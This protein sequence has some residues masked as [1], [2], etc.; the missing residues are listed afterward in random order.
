MGFG[1]AKLSTTDQLH[2]ALSN[3]IMKKSMFSLLV[4]YLKSRKAPLIYS[5]IINDEEN[6]CMIEPSSRNVTKLFVCN[7][8]DADTRILCH[9]SLQETPNV[10]IVANDSHVLFLGAYP[11]ALDKSRR[12][13]YNCEGRTYAD[14]CEICNILWK[15]CIAF[16]LV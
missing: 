4:N 3:T 11:C 9:A 5:T 7:H 13:F 10:M 15:Y 1:H 2:F 16:P 8:E 12:C 6:T 14:L